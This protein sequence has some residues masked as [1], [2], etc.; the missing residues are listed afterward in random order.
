MGDQRLEG[1]T[2]EQQLALEDM[3]RKFINLNDKDKIS[4]FL[5]MTALGMRKENLFKTLL[6]KDNV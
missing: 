2:L 1:L 4:I 6:K 3:K 5:D